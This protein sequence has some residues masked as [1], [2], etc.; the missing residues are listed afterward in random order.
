MS[1]PVWYKP[2]K[3]FQGF[4]LDQVRNWTDNG[5][6]SSWPTSYNSNKLDWVSSVVLSSGQRSRKKLLLVTFE[7]SVLSR[8]F[9]TVYNPVFSSTCFEFFLLDPFLYRCTYKLFDIFWNIPVSTQV[10][11]FIVFIGVWEW[12]PTKTRLNFRILYL[13]DTSEPYWSFRLRF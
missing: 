2:Q 13:L 11:G 12:R 3:V 5:W 10:R 8:D 9:K 1:I 4:D 7:K 6:I